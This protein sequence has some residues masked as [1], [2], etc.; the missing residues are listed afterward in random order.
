MKYTAYLNCPYCGGWKTEIPDM[1]AAQIIHAGLRA[2]RCG[3]EPRLTC[4][5]C[6][7][8]YP[9]SAALS[10]EAQRSAELHL[11]AVSRESEQRAV[12]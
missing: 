5:L 11:P 2:A 3:G 9:T 8:V 6:R 12:V 1:S 7:R 4:D 10:F